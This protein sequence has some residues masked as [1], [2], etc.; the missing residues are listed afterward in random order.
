MRLDVNPKSAQKGNTRWLTWGTRFAIGGALSVVVA[1]LAGLN[2]IAHAQ[3][4]VVVASTAPCTPPAIAHAGACFDKTA[5][6]FS[7]YAGASRACGIANRRL[8]TLSELISLRQKKDVAVHPT[9]IECSSTWDAG[10]QTLWC[11]AQAADG[12]A[13]ITGQTLT[14][15]QLS[16]VKAMFRCVGPQR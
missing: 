16:T 12:T 13:S 15:A 9:D 11:V 8:A 7:S 3:P 2:P 6:V 4:R 10:S 1:A 5:T 14:G